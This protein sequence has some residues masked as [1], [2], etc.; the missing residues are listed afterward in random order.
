MKVVSKVIQLALLSFVFNIGS[1]VAMPA[2]TYFKPI[3]TMTAQISPDGKFVA[4]VAQSD[5]SQ[6]LVI[7]SGVDGSKRTLIDLNTLTHRDASI[8]FIRWIGPR[9]I[10]AQFKE[11]KKGVRNLLDTKPAY[12][13]LVLDVLG[14]ESQ[15]PK[16]LEVKTSGWLVHALP[17]KPGHFLYAKSGVYSKV[18]S[19]DVSKLNPINQKSSK[20][21]RKDG[22]QFTAKNEVASVEGYAVRWFFDLKGQP[23]SVLYFNEGEL[24]L[25]KIADGI[26]A[27]AIKSW[28]KEDMEEEPNP[29]EEYGVLIP[30]SKSAEADTYFCLD[31]S[32]E[33]DRTVYHC[34]FSTGEESVVFRS[35]SYDIVDLIIEESTG[36]LIGVKVVRDGRLE[37]QYIDERIQ[38]NDEMASLLKTTIGTSID[39]AVK[40]YYSET[41]EQPGRYFIRKQGQKSDQFV[42]SKYP[43]LDGWLESRQYHDWIKIEGMDIPYVLTMPKGNGP[44]PLI[45]MPH[46]GPLG[47]FD[48]QYFDYYT[49]FFVA[50]KYAVLRVN[51]RGSSGYSAELEEAGIQQ[52]GNLILEDIY[53]TTK[54]VS[55]RSD[56]MSSKICAVGMS[57]GGYAA[58]MM[59]IKHQQLFRCAISVAGVTDV[60][61]YLNSPYATE[62][63]SKWLLENVG[64]T[65][66]NYNILKDVSPVY[67]AQDLNRPVFIIHGEKDEVVDIEHMHR[68]NMM[69][70]KFDKDYEWKAY[71]DMAHGPTDNEHHVAVFRSIVDFLEENMK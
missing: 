13:L 33:K 9:Y 47:I 43:H 15:P 42:A 49:Q 68:M 22:G 67:L 63:Q 51:Y 6:K 2:E 4:S 62:A 5:E 32:A 44:Y 21:V 12:R 36:G 65:V 19:L 11:I 56:I 27:T 7:W 46:G 25:S 20:L 40:L 57:Y 41:H 39:N 52:W 50:N 34:N 45:V 30:V 14:P 3:E 26:S 31:T 8:R 23:E 16:I 54:A 38:L 37:Y 1:A 60:N 35:D 55:D 48:H 69:L 71:P 29:D 59:A 17:G 18:Y 61:L 53:Q 28:T 58:L 10:V 66:K 24:R 70:S 64:D